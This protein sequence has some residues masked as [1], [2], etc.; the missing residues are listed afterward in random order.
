MRRTFLAA[1]VA[2][3]G[4]VFAAC[5]DQRSPLPTEPP[6]S[7]NLTTS[8]PCPRPVE[9][10]ALIVTLFAPRDLLTFALQ[11]Q[12]D[13]NLKMSRG[14]VAGARKVV[15]AF[16]DFTVKTY[17]Q[18]KLRDPNGT[19]P[20]GTDVFAVRLIDGLLCWVGLPPS[21]LVLGPPSPTGSP[22]TT[23]VI[24]PGGGAFKAT[25]DLSGLKVDAGTVSE[26][27]LWVITRRDDLAQ[28]GTCVTTP[29]E[30]VPLCVDFSVV[31]AQDLAKPVLVVVCQIEG[32]PEG[33]Q[34]AHQ[35]A[36]NQ[37]ELLPAALDPFE[38]HLT[39]VNTP[40]IVPSGLGSI[41]RAVW[42]FGSL[43]ARVLGPKRAYAGHSGLG[44]LVAPKLSNVIAVRVAD[45]AQPVVNTSG[46][47]LT[48]GGASQ[49][50]LAQVVTP[51]RTGSLTKVSFPLSCQTTARLVVEIRG[52]AEGGEPDELT[53]LSSQSLTGSSLP[54]PNTGAFQDLVFAEPA[55]VVAGAPYAIILQTDQEFSGS[56]SV[57][58]GPAGD[59]YLG[60]HAFFDARPNAA[61]VWVRL[62]LDN[63]ANPDDLP[64]KAF[65]N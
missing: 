43:V 54:G 26:D 49:Q 30:Q 27:R 62:N 39:C 8:A 51:G 16:I 60:G 52:V 14:D 12:N 56:C 55:S 25:D 42:R 46:F 31:P 2:A 65:V 3:G 35:L 59:P 1:A 33:L 38:P 24:G 15:L 13:I 10:A 45:Q 37:F 34:L 32:R 41:G 36:N 40:P 18:G 21:G 64:F 58:P 19:T 57:L 6:V 61:G 47:P 63:S 44:G 7:P 5:S 23:K 17:Y 50:Q 53:L 4:V 29:L 11:M 20:P 22:V 28:A 9:L 48:I